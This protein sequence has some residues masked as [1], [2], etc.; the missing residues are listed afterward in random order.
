MFNRI[1]LYI[2]KPMNLNHLKFALEVAHTGSFTQAAAACFVTQPTLSNGIKHLED[3][4][5]GK[6]FERTTRHVKLTQF[7]THMLPAI[8]AMLNTKRELADRAKLYFEPDH[9]LL[10]IGFSPLLDMRLINALVSPFTD[11]N[12]DVASYFKECFMDNLI[13]CLETGQVNMAIRP[14]Q[15]TPKPLRIKTA[16]LPFYREPI[17]VVPRDGATS[18]VTGSGPI[19]INQ[20]ADETFILTPNTCGHA[21]ATR[22]WFNQC[23]QTIKEYAGQAV[24]YQ[25]MQEWAR[26]GLAS[27]IL[28]WSKIAPENRVTARQLMIDQNTPTFIAFELIWNA[29]TENMPITEAFLKHCTTHL[30]SLMEGLHIPNE[31]FLQ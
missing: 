12:P 24:N 16:T 22:S 5:G 10:A 8:Q 18:I 28:P 3:G 26:L 29:E 25:V 9:K 15:H 11:K 21:N 31:Q 1:F 23:G 13:I 14:V 4:L 27:A 7:G 17:F 19:T 20:L 2:G 6:L 30:S